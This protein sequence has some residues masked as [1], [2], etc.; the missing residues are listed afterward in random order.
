MVIHMGRHAVQQVF[1]IIIRIS[2]IGFGSF[3]Q[4]VENGCRFC[5]VN[6][7]TEQPD[8]PGDGEGPYMAFTCTIVTGNM[9]VIQ[10]SCAAEAEML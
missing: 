9:T 4:C 7:I 8:F 1:Q 5:T 2:F 3:H 10:D 6:G